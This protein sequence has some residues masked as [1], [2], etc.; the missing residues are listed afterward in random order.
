[1]TPNEQTQPD[2]QSAQPAMSRRRLVLGGTAL[3]AALA[4]GVGAT[5]AT[6]RAAPAAS[7]GSPPV[8]AA[9]TATVPFHGTHQAGVETAAQAFAAFVAF[10]LADGTDRSTLV[11]LMRLLSDD[12]ARLTQG[13]AALADQASHLA[14]LTASL[15]ITFGFGPGFFRAADLEKQ[16]PASIGPLPAFTVDRLQPQWTGGDLLVQ[17]CA[18]DVITVAHALRMVV[19]DA[20]TFARVRWI[21]RGFRRAHAMEDPAT[22]QRNVMGIIDGT[23]NPAPGTESFRSSIWI[24]DGPQWLQGGSTLIVRR[25]RAEMETW[26]VTDRLTRETAIGR[27]LDNGAP[28]TGRVERDLPDFEARDELGFPVIPEYSHVRLAKPDNDQSKLLRR[29]Y[30]YDDGLSPEGKT[31]CGLIFASYQA[32]IERQFVPVQRRIAQHDL[33]NLWVTPIG[34]AVFAVPPGCEPGGWIGS[35]LLA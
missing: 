19:T 2:S 1:M 13:V 12:A 26:G 29:A 14:E 16:R 35:T 33:L 3:G 25:I 27:R 17:I 11:R 28:L 4:G 5:V 22:T 23:A 31:D 32:D 10:D 21:Q 8:G 18:D 9:G 30:N 24:D 6:R 34:S 15:T 7:P 20:R